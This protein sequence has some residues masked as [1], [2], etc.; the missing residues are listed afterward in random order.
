[1]GNKIWLFLTFLLAGIF[2]AGIIL[3]FTENQQSK[4]SAETIS[5]S[6]ETVHRGTVI[7]S[8]KTSGVVEAQNE[9]LLLSPARS[10][11]KKVFFEAGSWIEKGEIIL[12]LNKEKLETEIKQNTAQ[13]AMK[14][15]SLE[16][17]K[18]K[19]QSTQL[20]LGYNEE[21]KKLRI[22]T[23]KATWA[24]QKKLLEAGNISPA[25]IEKTKQ[26]LLVAEKDLAT[27]TQKNAIRIKQLAADQQGLM[28]QIIA[29]EK[30]IKD[31]K[32]LLKKMD[33]K[34]PSAGM[35][36]SVGGNKGTRAEVDKMLV[37]FADFSGYK[38]L[39]SVDEKLAW[40]VKTGNRVIVRIGNEELKGHIGAI[41]PAAENG[42]IQ[43]NVHLQNKTHPKLV[44]NN[45][46][47]LLISNGKKENVLR[48]K[49]VAAFNT[50][51]SQTVTVKNG[52]ETVQTSILLGTVGNDY[53]EILSGVKEGDQ[54]LL[55]ED[56][57]RN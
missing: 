49:R 57:P 26:E 15:N 43:F 17:S 51:G 31:K 3:Y 32:E 29:Q 4:S 9:V 2:T 27:L 11:I 37:R 23:L 25:R 14:Q 42:I 33:I 1:M 40:Q 20:D 53:C 8:L 18:L 21:V 5:V 35:I 44:A 46:V 50:G 36:L 19:A 45:K 52:K 30:T 56:S 22:L 55:N 48:I 28:L 6:V 16:R 41:A 12:Q 47:E 38:I 10:T 54:I 34:A 24:D 13:L 7:S 39:G